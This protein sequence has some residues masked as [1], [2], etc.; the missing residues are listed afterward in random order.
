MR[1][2]AALLLALL[3]LAAAAQPGQEQLPDLT[4]RAFE[5]RG[6]LQISLPNLERQPLRGFAPPPRTYVVPGSRQTYVAPYAQRLDGLP[7]DGLAAPEP[8]AVATLSPLTGRIDAG[9]GRYLSRLGRFT[10]SAGGLG[11]DL[12]YSGFSSFTPDAFDDDPA[13]ADE[14]A[15]ADVFDGRL[16]YTSPGPT[17]FG[18]T[19]DG[20]YQ[21][22]RLIGADLSRPLAPQ[23]NR[24]GRMIGG[25]I[26]VAS[27][28]P[29]RVPF[30]AAA[31]FASTDYHIA[32]PAG[33]PDVVL[34]TG[35]LDQFD[36][37]ET[38][39]EAGGDVRFG[40]VR[41]D[42]SGAFAGLGDEGLGESLTAYSAGAAVRVP[43]GGGQLDLGARFLGYDAS[44]LNGGGS[45]Q[46]VGPIVSFT[47]PMSETTRFF[48]RNDPHVERR[49]LGGLFRENPYAVPEPVVAPNLHVVDGAGGVEVQGRSVRFTAFGGARYSPVYQYFER[50]ATGGRAGG[51]YEARYG[52]AVVFLGGGSATFYAPSGF[53][54]TA[55][56]E[57]RTGTLREGDRDLPYFAPLVGR[58]SLALP[59]AGERGLVQVTGTAESARPAEEGAADADAWATLD[60]EA[61]YALSTGLGVLLRAERLAGRAERWPGFPRP[62]AT[63]ILGLRAQW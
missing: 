56:A 60:A 15:T 58:L 61:H 16:A 45:S 6:D 48:L 3:P 36:Q 51:L 52:E 31:R 2:L 13:L 39:F 34:P 28:A 46:S 43:F 11:V 1:F 54:A 62:P 50:V 7:A 9:F 21:R 27:E 17:R 26:S 59:F 32:L 37:T 12:D 57:A 38:R 53:R 8:P 30:H 20:D 40:N 18:F 42:A 4:P 23:P 44:A 63:V 22:Y 29:D 24:I 55:E 41:V 33:M 5:I 49:G 25:G 19:L 47:L 35:F 10:L 14:D